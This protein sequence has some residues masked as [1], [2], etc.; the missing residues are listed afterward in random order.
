MNTEW[1]HYI[2]LVWILLQNFDVVK[3]LVGKGG[4]ELL[5]TQDEDGETALDFVRD[6]ERGE[7]YK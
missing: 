6:K 1:E 4:T 3:F 5:M 7:V 2:M